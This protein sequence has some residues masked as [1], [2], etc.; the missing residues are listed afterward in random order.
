ME[1]HKITPSLVQNLCFLFFLMFVTVRSKLSPFA[2]SQD[3]YVP[4]YYTRFTEV[5]KACKLVLSHSSSSLNF[6]VKRANS[7][8]AELSFIKGDWRQELGESPIMPFDDSDPLQ[9]SS[10]LSDPLRLVTFNLTHFDPDNHGR[11]INISGALSIGLSRSGTVPVGGPGVFPGFRMWPGSSELVIV[12]EGVYTESEENG[13][14]RVLCLL[15][16]SKLPSRQ[17]DSVDPW[18]WA[19]KS[20][21][22]NIQPQLVQDD[23]ILL[24]L[25][26]P[27]TFMLTSRAVRGELSSLNDKSSRKY[28][29]DVHLTSQ[30][31]AYSNYQFASEKFIYKACDN[32]YPSQTE[33]LNGK[34]EVYKGDRFCERLDSLVSG[35]FLNVVPNWNCNSTDEYCSKLGPFES[36]REIK[37]SDGGFANVGLMMQDVR[38]EQIISAK[39]SLYARVSAV[40]RVVPPLQN[41]YWVSQRSGL[42]GSTLS[43]EGIWNS[44]TGQLCMVG[45]LGLAKD[46][47]H[48]RIYLY[49]PTSFSIRQRNLLYGKIWS[50][51]ETNSL[52]YPLTF[53]L[54]VHPSQLS[55]KFSRFPPPAYI[56][57]KIKFA[58][59][60]LERNEPF[61]FSTTIKK[62]LLS[63]PKKGDESD[64]S[65]SLSNLADDLTLYVSAI[66]DPLPEDR[67]AKPF[68]QLEILSIGSWF[69]RFWAYQNASTLEASDQSFDKTSTTEKQLLLNVSAQLTLSE[70]PYSNVSLLYLEG[71]YNPIDGKMYLI[72]CRDA[73]ASWKILFDSMDLEDGLDCLIEVKVEYP[74]TTARWFMN[75]MAKVFITSKRNDDDALHFSPI[76]LQTLPIFYQKQKEDILTRR[77][78]EGILC[79]L[80]LSMV[81]ACILSQL[82]YIRDSSSVLPYISLIMLG[83]QALGYSIPLITGAETLFAR[84]AYDSY[85]TPSQGFEKN[86]QFQIIDY[87]VKILVLSAFLL[88]V[89][90]GQ[91]VWKSRNRLLAHAPLE[92]RRV[93]SDRNVFLI[94]LI[95]HFIGFLVVLIVHG[96]NDS[97]RATS[98]ETY[99]EAN[100]N[101]HKLHDSVVQIEEYIGLV[102]DFFLLPQIIGNYLWRVN[103][104]PL[105]KAYYVGITLVRILPHIYDYLRA[106]VFNPY[107]P[108]DY[109]FV[110][111]S[112]DFYS[113]FG[114]IAIP[115][116][117]IVFA[118]IIFIQQR[119]R[120]DKHRHG[121][122]SRQKKLM[123][124]HSG[125]Y[126]KLPSIAFE[127]ELVSCANETPMEDTLSKDGN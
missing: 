73:R 7:I 112:L 83:V 5:E 89:R 4:H 107:F 53:E 46:G 85:E 48:S 52:Y 50:I 84:I 116:A 18:D 81:I 27:K 80:T 14:E 70:K 22:S 102:Q 30:L 76:K 33:S 40:F 47:C 96:I 35:E 19:K 61:E 109:E 44:S 10:I 110:N 25:R 15:G 26:Y 51:N 123:P 79:I 97:R 24:N 42:D 125:V 106:P 17:Q 38:C 57:S 65:I 104:K 34:V 59:A 86:Q 11:S 72:G 93:P 49:F 126:E 98:T 121:V 91:K 120:Y 71:L 8:K 54:P 62:S 78:V 101:R 118:V 45:C 39:N 74:P 69:H 60:F 113:K 99:I 103:C 94:S 67:V 127:A 41:H 63:Y 64:E 87:M 56:Y 100:G 124:L 21:S 36:N 92:P 114:D 55:M 23:N 95:I 105:R 31:G 66:P 20:N 43:A 32:H 58:G 6:D 13:G 119:W 82:F 108:Q 88:T 16:H 9:N 12:F 2:E 117:A 111:P 29:D 122:Q 77:G 90:L 37:A 68:L 3:P 75:P 115:V 28:F 1:S